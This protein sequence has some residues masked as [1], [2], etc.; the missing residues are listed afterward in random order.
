MA[1]NPKLSLYM[2]PLSKISSYFEMVDLAAEYGITQ[3]EILNLLDMS[4]PDLERARQLRAYADSKGIRIPCVSAGIS[5][6]EEDREAAIETAMAYVEVAGILGS[7]YFHHTIALNFSDPDYIAANYELFYRRGIDAVRRIYD[8][9]QQF[10][11]RTIYEDQGFVFN[12]KAAFTRFLEDVQRD[13]GVVADMGNI[14]FVDEQAQ[15]FIP[16]FAHWIVH[17]HV[18]DYL[19]TPAGQREKLPEEYT[20]RGGSLL[21]DCRIGSGS[22]DLDASFAALR[23]MGYQGPVSVESG[24]LGPDEEASF[25]HNLEVTSRYLDRYL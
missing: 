23:D 10:G 4:T 24:P 15:D 8:H 20:S 22:V 18:K 19:V 12:G 21:R 25:R 7:P 5:L 3:L 6:V 16:A 1:L 17:A 14:Q 2:P 11:I 13:V 9:A